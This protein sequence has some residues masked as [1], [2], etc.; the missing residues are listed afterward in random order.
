MNS[1]NFPGGRRGGRW[2]PDTPQIQ[3][4]IPSELI[5]RSP[6]L[7]R[8]TI[9]R[10][11]RKELGT[12]RRVERNEGEGMNRRQETKQDVQWSTYFMISTRHS[13]I[14]QFHPLVV[15]HEENRRQS[16]RQWHFF[17][18]FS[19]SR[20]SINDQERFS[21]YFFFFLLFSSIG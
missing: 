15:H 18:T 5:S 19:P 11:E 9:I 12:G 16:H 10:C 4:P 6:F 8:L 14:N 13:T 3:L 1:S 21:M 20:S 17:P 7:R 2:R